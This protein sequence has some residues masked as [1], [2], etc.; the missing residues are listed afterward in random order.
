MTPEEHRAKFGPA[1]Y[2]YLAASNNCHGFVATKSSLHNWRTKV[3]RAG[4]CPAR[5]QPKKIAID[6][7]LTMDNCHSNMFRSFVRDPTT[8]FLFETYWETSPH[9]HHV[10]IHVYKHTHVYTYIHIHM[11]IHIQTCPFMCMQM[12]IFKYIYIYIYTYVCI[13]ICLSV[14]KYVSM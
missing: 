5:N 3:S 7:Y 1:G 9:K 8:F 11:D 6:G 14:C 4:D 10:C 12:C 13:Y 2:R